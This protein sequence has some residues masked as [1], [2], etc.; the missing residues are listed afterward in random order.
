MEEC[1][2]LIR[3]MIVI[4]FLLLCILLVAQ[5]TL[6]TQTSLVPAAVAVSEISPVE[7]N[8]QTGATTTKER[9]GLILGNLLILSLWSFPM[10][11]GEGWALSVPTPP[12]WAKK[13][14]RVAVSIVAG[15]CLMAA[16]VVV[17]A[18]A[19]ALYYF[20]RDQ[21]EKISQI[22]PRFAYW[23]PFA[24]LGLVTDIPFH[25]FDWE[26]RRLRVSLRL[27]VFWVPRIVIVAFMID[28]A[29]LQE[30]DPATTAFTVLV[31]DGVLA[32]FFLLLYTLREQIGVKDVQQNYD[33]YEDEVA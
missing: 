19:F 21:P 5:C 15:I 10:S 26:D 6:P 14:H 2:M 33:T 16:A 28:L 22:V 13:P 30:L 4:V 31:I 18:V 17:G 23:F 25:V 27:I 12:R 32:A 24:L 11:L 7:D 29:I 1:V 8:P 3:R 9:V 20:F